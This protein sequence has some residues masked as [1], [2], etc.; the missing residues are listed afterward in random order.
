MNLKAT[1]PGILHIHNSIH[2][3]WGRIIAILPWILAMVP[4]VFWAFG[5]R[6]P[7]CGYNFMYARGD[8]WYYTWTSD[9][10]ECPKCNLDI[11]EPMDNARGNER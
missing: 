2:M 6:C 10:V 1:I 4:Y 11:D 8:F 5:V 3:G 7:R 9:L